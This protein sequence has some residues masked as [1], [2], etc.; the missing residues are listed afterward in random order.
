MSV[1]EKSN[2]YAIIAAIQMCSTGNVSENLAMAAKFIKEAAEHKANMAVLPEMFAIMGASPHDKVL[3]KETF[4][5]GKIQNFLSEQA[6][7]N[8]IWIVGG[9][10][11][12]QCNDQNKVRAAALVFND[13]GHCVARYDKI[14]LF[15]VTLSENET[16]KESDTTEAGDDIIV[17]DTPFGKLGLAVCYDI[18]FPEL[19]RCLLNKGAEIIALSSAFTVTTGK[20]HWEI[21]TRSRAIENFCYIIGACQGGTHANGT[22]TYGHSIIIEPWGSVA[23]KYEG[24]ESGVIYSTL[25]LDKIYSARKS[26]PS[27]NHQRIFETK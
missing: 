27:Q 3:E 11:P 14:H 12:I 8:K 16:Y 21:L 18:R 7:L 25:D 17:V 6:K 13:Q 20:A 24:I 4:G 1:T 10:I 19:F 5:H 9:T 23:A 15:D 26:I 22:N 2:K